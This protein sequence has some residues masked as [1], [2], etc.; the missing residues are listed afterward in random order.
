MAALHESQGARGYVF[1]GIPGDRAD[2]LAV[3]E[4]VEGGD[5][6]VI[7][8]EVLV[9]DGHGAV[10]GDFLPDA[11]ALVV[12]FA[13]DGDA[14]VLAGEE[15]GAVFRV[16]GDCPDARARL[17]LRLVARVV[18]QGGEGGA[19][20]GD[21]RVLVELVGRVGGRPGGFLRLLP[22]A[23][24]V[25]GVLEQFAVE[26]RDG[27]FIVAVVPDVVGMRR[28]MAGEGPGAGAAEGVVGVCLRRE[29]GA[30]VARDGDCRD[31][32]PGRFKGSFHG[33]TVGHGL[34]P[35][36]MGA[37]EV[38]VGEGFFLPLVHQDRLGETSIRT[39][40]P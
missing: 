29:D 32:I 5:L 3:V 6:E 4:Q 17:D 8:V 24:V 28:G 26:F 20:G 25:V 36:Q 14:A 15:H 37:V 30:V 16:V 22:V 9:M 23:N 39:V 21:G 27:E 11:A 19:G 33:Q 10:A 1:E 18:V 12:V 2:D 35:E 40:G 13:R 34:R 38:A 31:Q 7:P